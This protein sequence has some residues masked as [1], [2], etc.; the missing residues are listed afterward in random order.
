MATMIIITTA[1]AAVVRVE[2]GAAAADVADV[3]V[4]VDTTV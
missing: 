2:L 1:A 3:A 4:M